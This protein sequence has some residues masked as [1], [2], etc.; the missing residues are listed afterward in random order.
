[1]KQICKKHRVLLICVV[2]A[3]ATA[4]AFNRVRH[5]QFLNYD[6]DTY[7]TQNPHVLMGLTTESVVW[8]F[9]TFYASN[10]HPLT[11]L[12][13][14]LDCQLF[15]INPL[16]H[17]LTNLLLHILNTSLLFWVLNK[18][19]G[20][21]WPSAFVAALFALHPL[22]VESVAWVAERKD[23]LSAFFWM[24]TLAAYLRYVQRPAVRTYLLVVLAF[25]LGLMA[26][27][28]LVTLPFVL[29][30]LDYWPLGRTQLARQNAVSL[31]PSASFTL[32]CQRLSLWRLLAEKLPLFA[33]IIVSSAITFI[34][35]RAGGSMETLEKLPLNLRIVNVWLSYIDYIGKMIYPVRLAVFYPFPLR[36]FPL[37]KS[38]IWFVILIVFSRRVISSTKS[39]PYLIVGWLWYLGTLVPVIGLV[40]V[41][42]Q[43]MADRYTYLPS[44]GIFIMFAWTAADLFGKWSY[45][46]IALSLS[47]ILLLLALAISTHHQLRYWKN[48][49]TLYEHAIAVTRDNYVMHHNYGSVLLEKEQFDL[50]AE[51][52]YETLRIKPLYPR[53]LSGLGGALV[54]QGKFDEAIEC[55][56]KTL[57][58]DKNQPY[59]YLNLG[60]LYAKQGKYDLAI[61]N[62]EHALRLNPNFISAHINLA[63]V[64][65]TKKNYDEAARHCQ[66][67]LQINPYNTEAKRLLEIIMS[68]KQ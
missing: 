56:N 54:G 7:V 8:A 45:R 46:H 42:G 13:H 20:R 34:A 49:F 1:M 16:G 41:G 4:L 40:Q 31:P 62:Y 55:F 68:R 57:E 18:M 50:A 35:Q 28:M 26:K 33:F 44:I 61:Q 48:H 9:T 65:A 67:V 22:H 2:L 47:S 37:V 43:A 24:L 59:V 12:S 60:T 51:Q 39:R 3:V 25:A 58:L 14:M 10:W 19:T 36:G 17:H 53:A 5:N 6:D 38:I 32:N 27:P 63:K 15:G 52:F 64:L 30:L 29:L 23:V 66:L 21:I 11:W